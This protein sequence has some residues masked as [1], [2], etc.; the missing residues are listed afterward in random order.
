[1]NIAVIGLGSMGRRR[2]RILKN[3]AE[4]HE[5]HGIDTRQDRLIQVKSEIGSA[6]FPRSPETLRALAAYRGSVAGTKYA[7]SFMLLRELVP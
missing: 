3:R 6:P 4:G 5:L 2:L 7:E 1:M